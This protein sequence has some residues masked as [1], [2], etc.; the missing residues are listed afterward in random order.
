MYKVTRPKLESDSPG[1]HYETWCTSQSAA[2][3]VFKELAKEYTEV[4]SDHQGSLKLE[5]LDIR[6]DGGYKKVLLRVLNNDPEFVK[7]SFV[8][9]ELVPKP[10]DRPLLNDAEAP[11][12]AAGEHVAAG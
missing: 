6:V 12:E 7:Q 1:T 8:Q 5:V 4:D 2:N 9:K 10:M 11:K 3:D